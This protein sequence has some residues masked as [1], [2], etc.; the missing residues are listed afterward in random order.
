LPIV[1]LQEV[2]FGTNGIDE[3]TL[4]IFISYS[5]P[6]IGLQDLLEFTI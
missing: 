1:N 6:D 3:N 2:K 4:A 5:I